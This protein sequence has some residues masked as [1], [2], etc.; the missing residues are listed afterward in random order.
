MKSTRAKRGFTLVELLMVMAIMLVLMGLVIANFTRITGAGN[1]TNGTQNFVDNLNQARQ[2]AL[3]MNRNVEVRFY[4]LPGPTDGTTATQY[5]AMRVIVCDP[6]GNTST[7]QGTATLYNTGASAQPVVRLPDGVMIFASTQ[8]GSSGYFTTLLPEMDGA[9]SSSA[10]TANWGNIATTSLKPSYG[11]EY[12]PG[13]G[14]VVPVAYA[15]FQF[16]PNGGTNLD[17]LGTG[18]S[19]TTSSDKWFMSFITQEAA[20]LNATNPPTTQPAQNFIT[21]TVDPFSGRVRMLRPGG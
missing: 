7:N 10:P 3:G 17:P 2:L 14:T 8:P 16:K 18:G 6:T 13:N 9:G 19:S 5:R 21:V 11:T 4:F 20:T 1:L 15:A 12:F